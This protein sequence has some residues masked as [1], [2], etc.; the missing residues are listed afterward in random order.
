MKNA[1][2]DEDMEVTNNI[3]LLIDAFQSKKAL[4]KINDKIK[5]KLKDLN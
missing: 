2:I 1:K 5:L 3:L 4:K